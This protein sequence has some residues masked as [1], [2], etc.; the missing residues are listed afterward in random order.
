MIHF[1]SA[2]MLLLLLPWAGLV[3]VLGRSQL[4]ALAWL[5]NSIDPGRLKNWTRGTPGGVRAHMILIFLMGALLIVGA[6]GPW[7]PGIVKGTSNESTV[8]LV[9]DASLSMGAAD[10]GEHPLTGEVFGCR[11][12]LARTACLELIAANPGMRY[13]LISFSGTAVIHSPPTRDLQAL[14]TLLETMQYHYYSRSMGTRFS[15]AF[16]AVIHLSSPSDSPYQVVLFSDGELPEPDDSSDALEIFEAMQ[17]P[18]HTLAVGSREW[19]EMSVY[20]ITDLVGGVE[21]KRIAGTYRTRREDRELARIS[22]ATG[23]TALIAEDGTWSMVLPGVLREEARTG[24]RVETAGRRSLEAYPPALFL[25]LLL[26]E[27]IVLAPRRPRPTTRPL[28]WRR[29][30]VAFLLTLA[31]LGLS[32]CN[33]PL[34]RAHVNNE[35]GL[36]ARREADFEGSLPHF[37]RSAAFHVR[38]HIPVY[39]RGNSLFDLGDFGSA[40]DAYQQSLILEPRNARAAF[41]DGHALYLSGAAEIDS[42]GCRLDRT[43]DFWHRAIERFDT[44]AEI[45]GKNSRLGR[46]ALENRRVIEEQLARLE[47][48]ARD[49][50]EN[51]SQGGEAFEDPSGSPP[52]NGSENPSGAP[53]PPEGLSEE[54]RNHLAGEIERIHA[55]AETA[56]TF[57]QTRETQLEPE[58]AEAAAGGSIKW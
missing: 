29:V 19:Q 45:R 5:T 41:N 27:W 24:K 26:I 6:A 40:H 44:A 23:G 46:R 17:I 13:G 38:E 10:A 42:R 37:Q 58:S 51:Q 4:R 55:Q 43:R 36:E 49:C 9:I 11:F 28:P 25:V 30:G 33:S 56:G 31:G 57:R 53:P 14:K 7:V 18:V 3:L 16:D 39:N 12:D 15:S 22:R 21:D 54:E 1:H 47:E 8:I 48:L 2:P 34:V 35:K 20:D 32:G 52:P 50:P